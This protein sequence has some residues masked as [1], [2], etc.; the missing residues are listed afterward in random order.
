[1]ALFSDVDWIVILAVAAFL[2]F[3]SEGRD[4]VRQMGRLYGRALRL[5]SELLS[6]ITQS[7]GL[8][9]GGS[10]SLRQA[11]LGADMAASPA[12]P[13]P[14]APSMGYR[15]ADLNPGI[16]TQ[17]FPVSIRTV[18]TLAYGAALGPGMWSVATTNFPGEAVYLT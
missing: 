3:G 14:S 4:F 13:A 10:A 9:T 17:V 11:L 7:T 5:K 1:M 16:V 6:E 12:S 18:E 8:P 15:Q 2:L